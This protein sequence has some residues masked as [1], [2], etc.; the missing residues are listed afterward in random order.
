[1]GPSLLNPIKG[2]LCSHENFP[3]TGFES[4]WTFANVKFYIKVI[5]LQETKNCGKSAIFWQGYL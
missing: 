1:M 5:N 3:L 2:L 4:F